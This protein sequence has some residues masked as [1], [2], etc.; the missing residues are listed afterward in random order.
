VKVK[1]AHVLDSV[2]TQWEITLIWR[3]QNVENLSNIRL[4]SHDKR[5]LLSAV[6]GSL[7]EHIWPETVHLH[8][9]SVRVL[10]ALEFFSHRFPLSIDVL[11]NIM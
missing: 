1:T 7:S 8:Q 2:A 6:S 5:V 10:A 3:I 9:L 11:N 4:W